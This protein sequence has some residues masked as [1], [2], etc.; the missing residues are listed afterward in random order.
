MANRGVT[1]AVPPHQR[2]RRIRGG[3]LQHAS[4]VVTGAASGIGR[5]TAL[6]LSTRGAQLALL[7]LNGDAVADVAAEINAGGGVAKAYTV[8][9]SDATKMA[10]VAAEIVESFGSVDIVVNN[11]GVG[12][13]ARFGDMSAA[14][15]AWIRSINL[16]G[17][18]NGCMVFGK[19]MLAKGAGQVVNISSGLAYLPRATEPAYVTTKAAVLA[20]SRCLR[21]DWH[22]EG[23]GVSVVC[24]GFINTPIF[25]ST[26]LLG[27]QAA[28]K[29][30]E[31][32]RKLFARGHSPEKVARAVCDAIARD[33]AVVPVG[34]E[35]RLTW[36]TTRFTPL[37][38][39][40]RLARIRVV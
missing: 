30:R 11:A 16:D 29:A 28:P 23:I 32:G 34:W 22:R 6:E 33:A 37:R 5:A 18:I 7:D 40:R 35:A 24:P 3:S 27:D 8:D 25:E 14:D 20:F 4:V 21:A 26:R 39:E 36:W 13:S 17:V 1:K 2:A 9:V 15:W 10:A 38:L 12:M 31:R 19:P